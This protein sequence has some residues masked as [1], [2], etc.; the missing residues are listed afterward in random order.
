MGV[1]IGLACIMSY[2]LVTAANMVAE[3]GIVPAINEVLFKENTT[4]GALIFY[5]YY[6]I[7]IRVKG[8]IFS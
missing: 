3:K 8:F 6:V 2:I 7:L 1:I 5:N 4:K